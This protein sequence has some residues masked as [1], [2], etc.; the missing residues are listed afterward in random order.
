MVASA[1]LAHGMADYARLSQDLVLAFDMRDPAA[2]DRLNAHYARAFTFD[3]LAAEIWR[4]VYAFRQRSSRVPSNHLQATEAQLLVAQDAGFASWAALTEA[5]ATG[6]PP[7]PAYGIDAVDNVIAPRRHLHDD[8]WD[9]VLGVMKERGITG[10]Q[11]SGLMTDRV[12]A[13]L[14]GLEQVTG[15]WL[16]GSRQLTDDGLRHLNRMPQLQHLDLT[17]T[18][19]TDR[20]LEVLG[21]LPD[22][23]TFQMTW[24]SGISDTGV[25]HLGACQR[26][27]RVNLM[28]SATGDGVIAALQGK[29]SLH[30]FSSGR[31]ATDAGLRLLQG[32]PRMATWDTENG[33][34]H[35]LID[36]PFTNLGLE[37]LA[38]LDGVFELDI[39]WHA[40]AI[41]SDGFAHLRHLANLGAL[42]ADGALSDDVAMGHFASLPRLRTLRAQGT[43]ATDEGFEFLSHSASLESLW[44]RECPNLGSRGFAALSR[45]PS[46]RGLGVS[47]K[48][49][50]NQALALLPQLPSLRELTPLDVSDTGFAHI[51]RCARLER[52]TCMY[53][54]DTTDAATER[55]ADLRLKYSYAGLTQITDRSLDVLGHMP[56]LEQIDLFE[57]PGVTNAGLASLARLPSLHTVVLEGVQGVTLEG[58]RVFPPHIRVRYSTS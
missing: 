8:D 11:A 29:R 41:T 10:I 24:R 17:G 57:C 48:H 20:G 18:R 58:T 44:G 3:D 52:L 19:V 9:D 54:R 49:V 38:G 45:L 34:A 4:R 15:L 37:S 1:H 25:A 7:L 27:E 55:V 43:I 50:D 28:G 21:Q 12:L 30:A 56:S 33:G 40:R 36:G 31:L 51:G 46:L 35:L 6:A 22:L 16:D 23:R 42:G 2:L 47:C 26:L 13:R 5:A 32:L 14:A 39:F 53:C